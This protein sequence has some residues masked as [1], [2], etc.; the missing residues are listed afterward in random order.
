MQNANEVFDYS[1]TYTSTDG[2]TRQYIVWGVESSREFQ[3][4]IGDDEIVQFDDLVVNSG[5]QAAAA[6]LLKNTY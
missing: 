3:A 1:L 5:K 4:V 6:F 2:S